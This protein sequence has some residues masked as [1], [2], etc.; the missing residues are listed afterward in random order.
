MEMFWIVLAFVIIVLIGYKFIRD[1][2]NANT[3]LEKVKDTFL[4]QYEANKKTQ[5]EFWRDQDSE[6]SYRISQIIREEIENIFFEDKFK[7]R[8]IQSFEGYSIDKSLWYDEVR[9]IV[10]KFRDKVDQQIG[11]GIR[12]ANEV[13]DGVANDFKKMA[14]GAIKKYENSISKFISEFEDSNINSIEVRKKSAD[15]IARLIRIWCSSGGFVKYGANGDAYWKNANGSIEVSMLNALFSYV[16]NQD[17]LI[18]DIKKENKEEK[19]KKDA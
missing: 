14:N 7:K 8:V 19:E 16:E 1:L 6:V 17:R 15:A 2:K 3:K 5:R 11:F 10:E 13:I 18:A 9:P 4:E 12:D